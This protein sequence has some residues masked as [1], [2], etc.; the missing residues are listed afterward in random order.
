MALLEL[1]LLVEPPLPLLDLY[2]LICYT[3]NIS[4]FT[5]FGSRKEAVVYPNKYTPILDCMYK[6]YSV[7]TLSPSKNRNISEFKDDPYLHEI[8]AYEI[9]MGAEVELDFTTYTPNFPIRSDIRLDFVMCSPN[10]EIIKVQK[11]E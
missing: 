6:I 1:I 8:A 9:P 5:G 3:Y 11:R 7:S 10:G 2:V 4:S